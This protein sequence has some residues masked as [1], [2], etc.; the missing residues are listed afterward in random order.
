MRILIVAALWMV[1]C[2]DVHKEITKEL[3]SSKEEL[4]KVQVDKIVKEY[5]PRWSSQNTDKACPDNLLEIGKSIDKTFTED[6]FR[7]A[8]GKP[9]KFLCGDTLPAGASGLGV[10]SMGE[11]GKDNTPDDIRS[12]EKVK[13]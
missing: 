8:W 1:A 4:T 7:D 11:D 13:K 5:Y 10:Y 12:W 3:G 9:L 6:E 2:K